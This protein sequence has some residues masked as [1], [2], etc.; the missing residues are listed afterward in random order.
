MKIKPLF[1]TLFAAAMLASCG[2]NSQATGL[3]SSTSHATGLTSEPAAPSATYLDWVADGK[4]VI[5][6]FDCDNARFTYGNAALQ[7]SNTLDLSASAKIAC[8]STHTSDQVFNFIYVTE[9]ST[10]TGFNAGAALYAGI[11]GDKISEFLG[12][13]DDE[14]NGKSRAY[15][16][17]SFGSTVKWTKGKNAA[18]DAKIQQLVDASK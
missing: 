1:V 16:A 17:I 14:L 7:A 3:S 10:E 6:L 11:E 8:S 4:I 15:I 18:M 2:G 12:L 13:H 9:A 5:E